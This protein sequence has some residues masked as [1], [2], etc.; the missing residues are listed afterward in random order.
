MNDSIPL[1]LAATGQTVR[2]CHIAGNG[3]QARRLHEI[4]FRPGM[5]VEILSQGNPCI[6]RL[7]DAK[8]CFRK[9]EATNV[10]VRAT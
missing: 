10:F 1:G 9:N 6:V 2:I 4:G 7:A 5:Q 8:L 3:D